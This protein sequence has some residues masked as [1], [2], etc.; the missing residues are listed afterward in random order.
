MLKLDDDLKD[1][2]LLDA[3]KRRVKGRPAL[4]GHIIGTKGRE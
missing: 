4:V 2:Q 1:I 3:I